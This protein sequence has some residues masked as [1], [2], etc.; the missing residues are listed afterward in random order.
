MTTKVATPTTTK[1]QI[2]TLETTANV[3]TGSELPLKTRKFVAARK[4]P[5]HPK[6]EERLQN[7]YKAIPTLE[8]RAYVILKDLGMIE[9]V[10]PITDVLDE[11]EEEE[12]FQ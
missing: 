5:K 6:E 12:P 8:E 1:A 3:A 7:K 4:Q 2:V 9:S 11:E 10:E